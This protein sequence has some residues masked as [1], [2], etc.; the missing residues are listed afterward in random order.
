MLKKHE[1]ED[2]IIRIGGQEF[3]KKFYTIR[4]VL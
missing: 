4:Q 3:I 2:K 1:I